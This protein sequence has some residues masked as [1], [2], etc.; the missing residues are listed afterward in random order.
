MPVPI[1]Q[2]NPRAD[3]LAHKHEID[4]SIAEVLEA[5]SYILGQQVV[6][7]EQE[8]SAYLGVAHVVGVGNG[9][10]ALH[11]ALRACGIGRG[12]AVVTVSHT[13]VATVAA[14]E[15]VGA[16]PILV[17][18]DSITLTMDPDRLEAAIRNLLGRRVKAI[19]PV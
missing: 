13:A 8:F 12:D 14:I 4:A 7:F 6:A 9:T 17:D 1:L 5:G 11:L 2:T 3:Y 18:I 10:D 16:E 19:I 15:L